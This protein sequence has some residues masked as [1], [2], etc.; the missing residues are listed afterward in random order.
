MLNPDDSPCKDSTC[1]A[2]TRVTQTHDSSRLLLL[3]KPC[4]LQATGATPGPGCFFLLRL[5]PQGYGQR[6]CGCLLASRH[7]ARRA[8]YVKI[9]YVGT[10]KG[11][12]QTYTP[13]SVSRLG[14]KLGRR[15]CSLTIQGPE[16]AAQA[17]TA[18]RA[19][20]RRAQWEAETHRGKWGGS[21]RGSGSEGQPP[22]PTLP[23]HLPAPISQPRVA[24][25]SQ[26]EAGRI[27]ELMR[28]QISKSCLCLSHCHGSPT[29]TLTLSL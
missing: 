14:R 5:T 10:D 8:I 20:P 2:V 13:N 22:V 11:W 27:S 17:G 1:W 12:D 24:H 23:S 25:L 15:C 19:Q 3:L 29:P 21:S 18:L 6:S 26:E 4:Y 28:P 7:L 9:P 16:Q